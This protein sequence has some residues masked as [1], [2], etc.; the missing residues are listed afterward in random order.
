MLLSHETLK[1]IVVASL[2]IYFCMGVFERAARDGHEIY[3]FFSWFLFANIPNPSEETFTVTIH[4]I[5]DEIYDPPLAF[6]E[7]RP[8]FEKIR[9][10]PTEYTYAMREFGR[11]VYAGRMQLAK[12]HRA[13]FEEMFVGAS[14]RYELFVVSYD[15]ILHWKEGRYA[16]ST[17][18]GIFE[19]NR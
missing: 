14:A 10:S 18:L 1:R 17:S 15:P 12:E 9:Q 19:T 13:S 8:W 3:P 4:S 2:V 7:S 6:S 11:S 5:G 16:S